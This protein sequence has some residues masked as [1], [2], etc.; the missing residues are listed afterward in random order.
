MD[1]GGGLGVEVTTGSEFVPGAYERHYTLDG[2]RSLVEAS[3]WAV[4]LCRPNTEAEGVAG[5]G[6]YLY[7]VAVPAAS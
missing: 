1:D 4:R 3:G 7:L 5:A 6:A 2:L